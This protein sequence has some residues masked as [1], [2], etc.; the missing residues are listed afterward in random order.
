MARIRNRLQIVI[1]WWMFGYLPTQRRL[2]HYQQAHSPL[3]PL[4]NNCN[5]T[6]LHFLTCGGSESWNDSLLSPLKLLCHKQQACNALTSQLISN[7]RRF[8]DGQPTDLTIQ[9]NIGWSA[10]FTG[11]FNRQWI[12]LQQTYSTPQYS[13][14]M[15]TQLIKLFLTAVA[16]R[17]KDCNAH[18]HKPET[19][20]SETHK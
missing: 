20:L 14:H 15:T 11:L 4:C 3:C 7:T 10:L 6:D 5:E 1:H 9:S 19:N 2:V 17:W 16:T 8:L 13:S 12:E 18:L